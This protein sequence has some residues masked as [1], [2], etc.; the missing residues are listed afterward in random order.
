MSQISHV[1]LLI[2]QVIFQCNKIRDLLKM[3]QLHKLK[4]STMFLCLICQLKYLSRL[5]SFTKMLMLHS[6]LSWTVLLELCSN[7][8]YFNLQ[9]GR[10]YSKGLWVLW[11]NNTQYA[12]QAVQEMVQNGSTNIS[13]TG[14]YF[15]EWWKW[16][17][18]WLQT[19]RFQE[20]TSYDFN[21]PWHTNTILSVSLEC[22]EE[23]VIF[24]LFTQC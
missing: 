1:R 24:N 4:T 23:P 22:I 13:C 10:R 15:E 5:D 11:R 3:V 9:H 14:W 16:A 18:N 20:E 12:G 21:V 8:N 17:L 19:I 7:I 6:P 2:N